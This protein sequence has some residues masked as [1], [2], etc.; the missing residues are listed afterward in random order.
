VSRPGIW[1]P[2]IWDREGWE[3]REE[4]S[5]SAEGR[6]PAVGRISSGGDEAARQ[7]GDL[8]AGVAAQELNQHFPFLFFHRERMWGRRWMWIRFGSSVAYFYN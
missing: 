4:K 3:R 7:R 8:R 6:V 1:G 2:S 5:N